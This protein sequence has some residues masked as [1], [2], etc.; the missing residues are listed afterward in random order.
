M[1]G[2]ARGG[3]LGRGEA[4]AMAVELLS[5]ERKIAWRVEEASRV[6]GARCCMGWGF[7][8]DWAA[9]GREGEAARA[10]AWAVVGLG[11]LLE[12]VEGASQGRRC[13]AGV[14]E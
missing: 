5:G 2:E 3:E 12:V 6:W 7:P 13:E 14:N 1:R 9:A 8:G 11:G 4:S 10:A